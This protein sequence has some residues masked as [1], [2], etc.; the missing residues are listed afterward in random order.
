MDPRRSERLAEALRTEVE[1]LINYELD[2][3]RLTGIAVAVTEV[4][5]SK[6]GKKAHV[7][8]AIDA[9]ADQQAECLKAIENAK[10]YLKHQLSE[11]VDVFR[12]PD[13]RF[14]ADL[15][16]ALRLKSEALLRRVRKGRPRN[17]D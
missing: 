10:G 16:A 6:D 4:L 17:A 15:P 14:D 12:M 5:L 1:E 7:R 8:L 9:S 2:D 11:R 13:L 3:P